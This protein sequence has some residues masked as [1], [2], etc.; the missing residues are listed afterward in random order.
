MSAPG[1]RPYLAEHPEF[2][3]RETFRPFLPLAHSVNA[4]YVPHPARPIVVA[5]RHN[6]FDASGQHMILSEPRH[7]TKPEALHFFRELRDSLAAAGF[8]PEELGLSA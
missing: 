4:V 2:V 1:A 7:L 3:P 8:T 5:W 6:M